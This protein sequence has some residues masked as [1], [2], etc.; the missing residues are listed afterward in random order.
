MHLKMY[1]TPDLPDAVKL[2]AKKASSGLIDGRFKKRERTWRENIPR[3]LAIA[4]CLHLACIS[5][6]SRLH[7]ACILLHLACILIAS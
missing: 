7:L 5:L 3:R 2:D 4:S 6:A 1:F